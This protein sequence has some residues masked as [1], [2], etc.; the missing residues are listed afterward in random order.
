MY[1]SLQTYRPLDCFRSAQARLGQLWKAETAGWREQALKVGRAAL[2]AILIAAALIADFAIIPAALAYQAINRKKEPSSPPI[3][4]LNPPSQT[5]VLPNPEITERALAHPYPHGLPQG[6]DG[7]DEERYFRQ[8]IQGSLEEMTPG[9][10]DY[11]RQLLEYGGMDE[12]GDPGDIDIYRWVAECALIQTALCRLHGLQEIPL[13]VQ[14]GLERAGDI[15]DLVQDLRTLPRS[16]CAALVLKARAPDSDWSLTPGLKRLLNRLH[17]LGQT[18][19]M[20]RRIKE[21]HFRVYPIQ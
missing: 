9:R 16:E 19:S 13:F 21:V 8:A 15:E 20:S 5:L 6:A 17:G 11:F 18:L 2:Q 1:L 10:A 12:E 4:P 14:E 3:L 7:I